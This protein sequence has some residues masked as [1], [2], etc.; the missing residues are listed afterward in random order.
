MDIQNFKTNITKVIC[1]IFEN[2]FEKK[3]GIKIF[4]A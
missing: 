4:K 1:E 2:K 3:L